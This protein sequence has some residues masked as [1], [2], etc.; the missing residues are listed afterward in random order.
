MKLRQ[1]LFDDE[2]V[3]SRSQW[4]L[5][6]GLLSLAYAVA[7]WVATK[8]FG[9]NHFDRVIMI[10]LSL[11][12]LIPTYSVNAKRFRAIGRPVE[13]ALVGICLAAAVTLSA[14]FLSLP[15]IDLVIGSALFLVILWYAVDLGI[16]DHAQPVD[17][18]PRRA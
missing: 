8:Y 16:I 14:Q 10:F 18:R 15:R 7:G 13:L 5:G 4:W 9:R 2:G 17:R 12:I 11:V 6:I 1:L 3:I